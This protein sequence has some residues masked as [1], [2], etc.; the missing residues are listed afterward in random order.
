MLGW[1]ALSSPLVGQPWWWAPNL[2]ASYFY[3]RSSTL[4][5]PGSATIT[6][7]AIHLALSG[8]VGML[9]GILTPGGRLFGLGIAILWYLTCYFVLWKKIAP[10]LLTDASQ[11]LMIA[12]FWLYGS[13]L[14][15]HSHA[16]YR[17]RS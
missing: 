8:S 7:G 15:W 1:L 9:N 10:L 12:G 16:A 11:P 2:F 13:A 3:G 17:L 14:G 5:G 4:L 6:G